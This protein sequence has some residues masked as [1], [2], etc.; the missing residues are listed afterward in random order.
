MK[1]GDLV[2]QSN[3][4]F[5]VIRLKNTGAFGCMAIVKSV[6]TGNISGFPPEWL[7]RIKTDKFCP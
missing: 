3:E 5:I 7:T 1:I 2:S 4:L 6:T